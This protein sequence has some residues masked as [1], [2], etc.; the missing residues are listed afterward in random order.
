MSERL[1]LICP[2]CRGALAAA[3][4]AAR[5]LACAACGRGYPRLG[6]APVLVA[7]PQRQLVRACIQ[8]ERHRR[9]QVAEARALVEAAARSPERAT[10]LDAIHR[11][12]HDNLALHASLQDELL[13]HVSAADVLAEAADGAHHAS[14]GPAPY[15][16]TLDYLR[17][18]WCGEPEAERELAA[19]RGAIEP[20]LRERAPD[21][22]RVL[23]LGAGAG[24]LAWDLGALFDEVCAVDLS[25]MMAHQLAAVCAGDRALWAL[26]TT[27]C[28][29][30]EALAR[31]LRASLGAAG[32]DA[33]TRRRRRERVSY[34]VA[35]AARLP[36]PDGSISAVVSAFF[37]DVAPLSSWLGEVRRVLAPNGAF[38]HFGP[39][40]YHFRDRAHHLAA[41]EV[42]RRFLDA[43]FEIAGEDWVRTTHLSPA[44]TMAPRLY[45][46]WSLCAVVRASSAARPGPPAVGLETV[47]AIQDELRYD[48]RGVLAH[49]IDRPVDA[50]LQLPSGERF[51]GAVDVLDIL[52]LLDGRR[53]VR[54][55]I[56]A[57]LARCTARED[58]APAVLGALR[59]LASRGVVAAPR[60]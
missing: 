33:D 58:P 12:I 40:E 24:R 9:Q 37:T 50:S 38:V 53:S 26:D 46:C 55:V 49:G 45:D 19:V 22:R 52:R 44:S 59:T 14:D 18:D 5:R 35:D 3:G 56:A 11:A 51:E 8:L 21:R 27:S 60:A 48:L 43:G 15:L 31:P 13:S 7:E 34:V 36:L 47:L 28:L 54:E 32:D 42:R 23:V 6:G 29:R 39:L 17:R 20:L 30:R 16:T 25:V 41:D 57:L 2:V 4:D 10:L 1:P